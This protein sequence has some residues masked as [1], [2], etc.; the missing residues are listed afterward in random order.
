MP[1]FPPLNTL[2]AYQCPG[3]HGW[4]LPSNTSCCVAHAPGT[5][6]HHFE[7]VVPGPTQVL[8]EKKDSL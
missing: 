2:T 6:C 4:F 8:N 3:C 7:Q 5:C 1:Y